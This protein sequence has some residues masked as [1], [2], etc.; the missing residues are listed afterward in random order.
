MVLSGLTAVYAKQCHP[1][2]VFFDGELTLPQVNVEVVLMCDKHT[3]LALLTWIIYL[4][5]S[6]QQVCACYTYV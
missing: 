4:C 1:S 3:L 5:K 6:S 2:C